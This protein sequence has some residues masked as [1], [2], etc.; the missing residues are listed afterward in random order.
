MLDFLP[1]QLNKRL[2]SLK[3]LNELRLRC[4]Y[5]VKYITKTEVGYLSDCIYGKNDLYNVLLTACN[6]S[7]YSREN[8][9]KQGFITVNGGVRVGIAGE[10][11]SERGAV[12]GI[13]SVWGLTVRIPN[14][15]VGVSSVFSNVYKGGSV[16]VISPSG[17]GKTTFLRDFTLNL[18]EKFNKNVVVVDERD[19]IACYTANF[20]FKLGKNVDV[21]TYVTKSYGFNQ[22]VRTLNPNSIVTDE[23]MSYADVKAVLTAIYSGVDV[24]ASVH[25]KNISE[26]EN[27]PFIN[28]L[29]N[30]KA[31][32][33][34]VVVSKT[35]TGRQYTCYDR[36]LRYLCGY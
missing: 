27:K 7:L 6:G 33:Y 13:K 9:L 14:F 17:V 22:G 25:A 28:D 35:E 10:F 30:K 21:L 29:I 2:K 34:Y 5:P 8:E 24:I 16:L 23:L 36:D 26:L 3:N 15:I 19:E 32:S 11:V 12:V 31:F 4:D 1:T 20:P 18:S